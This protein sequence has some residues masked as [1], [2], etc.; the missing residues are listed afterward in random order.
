MER[1]SIIWGAQR[2]ELGP[3]RSQGD[4]HKEKPPNH[5][6]PVVGWDAQLMGSLPSNMFTQGYCGVETIKTKYEGFCWC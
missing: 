1:K 3:V 5:Y 6:C 2:S 4:P